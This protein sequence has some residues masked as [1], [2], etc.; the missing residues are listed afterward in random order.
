MGNSK[1]QSLAARD[2]FSLRGN[3]VPL[4]L[5]AWTAFVALCPLGLSS[6][7]A[8]VLHTLLFLVPPCQPSHVLLKMPA[9]YNFGCPLLL[10]RQNSFLP[11]RNLFGAVYIPL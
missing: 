11:D 6:G 4:G 2:A 10:L 1:E 7:H 3:L 5:G 8:S 9:L